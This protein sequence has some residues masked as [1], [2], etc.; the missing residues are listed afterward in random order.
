MHNLYPLTPSYTNTHEEASS[1]LMT[2]PELA[3]YLG[4][5]RNLAYQLLNEGIIKGFRIGKHW[6]VSKQAVD[7]YIAQQSDLINNL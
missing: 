7:L 3:E 4:I 1:P 6:R 5:G 2:P